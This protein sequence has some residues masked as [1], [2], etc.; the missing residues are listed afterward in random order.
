MQI[1]EINV[2]KKPELKTF[3]IIFCLVLPKTFMFQDFQCHMQIEG[4]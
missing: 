3:L 4:R 1:R 2:N